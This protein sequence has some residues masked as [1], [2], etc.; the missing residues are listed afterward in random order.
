MGRGISCSRKLFALD[1]GPFQGTQTWPPMVDS[2]SLKVEPRKQRFQA[3][4]FQANKQK[5]NLLVNFLSLL[6]QIERH[7]LGK[8]FSFFHPKFFV[9]PRSREMLPLLLLK[10]MDLLVP[11]RADDQ[12][13]ENFTGRCSHFLLSLGM[14]LIVGADTTAV[15]IAFGIFS[16]YNV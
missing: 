15:I 6:L 7:Q 11:K 9:S 1:L 16:S 4:L 12:G 8:R 2:R 3:F 10:W 14:H 5:T 13:G